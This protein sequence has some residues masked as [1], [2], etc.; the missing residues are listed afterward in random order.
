MDILMSETC[1]AHNNWNKITSDIKLVFHSS[2]IAMMHGP[3]NI[4]FLKHV[5]WFP[6]S[7]GLTVQTLFKSHLK[8]D[9]NGWEWEGGGANTYF[10]HCHA[11]SS[12]MA[13]SSSEL[14]QKYVRLPQWR[15]SVLSEQWI[16]LLEYSN[17]LTLFYRLSRI[18]DYKPEMLKRSTFVWAAALNLST[19]YQRIKNACTDFNPSKSGNYANKIL[20]AHKE[21]LHG[22]K[23]LEVWKLCK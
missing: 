10:W 12:K 22:F 1:W 11:V 14:C 19:I 20:T 9:R 8:I 15:H 13:G 23:P 3:I 16:V 6:L 2:T 4:R 5:V 7:G 17:K 18:R 21:R